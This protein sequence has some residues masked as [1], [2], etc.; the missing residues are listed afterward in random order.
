[1]GNFISVKIIKE[2]TPAEKLAEEVANKAAAEKAKAE[3][4]AAEK[5]AAEKLAAEKLAAK[6]AEKAKAYEVA[7][8]KKADSLLKEADASLCRADALLK[9]NEAQSNVGAASAL[10]KEADALLKEADA[11]LKEASALQKEASALQKEADGE[12][13]EAGALRKEADGE[14][15]EA[16]ALRKEVELIKYDAFNLRCNWLDMFYD[17]KLEDKSKRQ[18]IKDKQY[19]FAI[20]LWNFY[21]KK[22]EALTIMVYNAVDGNHVDSIEWFCDDM[23][24]LIKSTIW[25][26]QNIKLSILNIPKNSKTNIV[27]L[28]NLIYKKK[29]AMLTGHV[30]PIEI[31]CPVNEILGYTQYTQVFSLF[32]PGKFQNSDNT[33]EYN[34]YGTI[35]QWIQ[36]PDKSLGSNINSG[37]WG[38]IEGGFFISEKY[39]DIRYHVAISTHRYNNRSDTLGGYGFYE[40]GLQKEYYSRIILSPN[41]ILPPYGICFDNN[42]EGKLF[43]AGWIAT[44]LFEFNILDK[45][46]SSQ[47]LLSDPLTWTFYAH[48]QNFDRSPICC[49]PPQ[50]FARRL[51]S[52]K[53]QRK[54]EDKN[55]TDDYL[56]IDVK[57]TLAFKGRSSTETEINAINNPIYIQTGGEI[58]N[59]ICSYWDWKK[60]NKEWKDI[61][62]ESTPKYM[63]KIP[64]IKLPQK[65]SIW[66]ANAKY[67]KRD[68]YR[69]I[70][71]YL[72]PSL[73]TPSTVS[74]TP[75]TML[76]MSGLPAKLGS[77]LNLE[78]NIEIGIKRVI[79]HDVTELDDRLKID[80]KVIKSND[81]QKYIVQGN[82]AGMTL[83]RYFERDGDLVKDKNGK[84]ISI[85]NGTGKSLT[86]H[87]CSE[88]NESNSTPF[89]KNQDYSRDNP[90]YKFVNAELKEL[91]LEYS[92]PDNNNN[93]NKEREAKLKDGT[94]IYYGIVPFEKQPAIL[95]L[96]NDF[97]D[98]FTDVKIDELKQRYLKLLNTKIADTSIDVKDNLVKD[99]LVN[100]D[101]ALIIN[102]IQN[103]Y[104]PIAYG[105]SPDTI[106]YIKPIITTT[107]FSDEIPG[108]Y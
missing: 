96:I 36:A 43:G 46:Q 97:P 28:D 56:N 49:Y 27:L 7:K 73:V 20:D 11:L 34:S 81:G 99:N 64:N 66:L 45:N 18:I 1:M 83:G 105:T 65:D 108:K 37:P 57:T 26:T 24:E 89:L 22:N 86:I 51:D 29:I 39:G 4:L 13:I 25:Y 61:N 92:I 15:I 67:Y 88:V 80:A 78:P 91:V 72:S 104:V 54:L 35:G 69:N 32:N 90:P 10:L 6:L 102:N 106:K 21:D 19:K 23:L 103:G 74:V 53:T 95:S 75:P 9:K 77:N 41:I 52:W 84:V 101:T 59:L 55:L 60:E 82:S 2:K 16:G 47:T 30:F 33:Y 107:M 14:K 87:T 71:N 58:P 63:W 44:P 17:E 98:D 68:N 85:T 62:N 76:V 12:K 94:T 40:K 79:E 31:N 38:S 93:N 8:K 5:L 48:A 42:A 70:K 3:K 100:I 50:F